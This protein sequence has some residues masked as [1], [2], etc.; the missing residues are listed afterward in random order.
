MTMTADDPKWSFV[1]LDG[2]RRV[3]RVAEKQVISHEATVG[4]YN[5]RRGRDFVRGA[6]AMIAKDLRVN[7]EFYVAPVYNELIA[8]GA[9]VAIYNVGREGA[10]MYG[11]G[12]PDDLERFLADP[13]SQRAVA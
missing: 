8:E 2:A 5:F 4:I 10:G 13:V 1:G 7:G 9:R 12:I 6:E 3:T 11:M